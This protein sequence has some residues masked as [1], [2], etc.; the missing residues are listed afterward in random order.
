MRKRNKFFIGSGVILFLI[1]FAGYGLVAAS[2][3]WGDPGRC[4]HPGFH[5]RDFA[6][7]MLWRMDKKAKEL[8]L[9]EKQMEKYNGIRSRI[10]AQLSNGV[11]SR[12]KMKEEF[13]SELG[14][15]DPDV[16]SM[17][18]KIKKKIRKVSGL[19]EEN[20][21]LF[22]EF[23]ATLDNDQKKKVMEDIREKVRYAHR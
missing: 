13:R 21:D 16:K 6:E 5:K 7:F 1:L 2:G 10:E 14:K 17:A 4:F 8:D 12:K 23:Y 19:M 20:L 3:H 11:E 9:T 22:V 15:E 18:E